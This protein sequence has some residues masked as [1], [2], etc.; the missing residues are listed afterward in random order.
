MRIIRAIGRAVVYL[1][2]AVGAVM[3]IVTTTP[4]VFRWATALAGPWDDPSGDVL[5]VLGGAVTERDLIAADSFLRA[6]YAVLAWRE[7]RFHHI[8]LT[9][10]GDP[11]TPVAKLMRDVLVSHG[12]PDSAIHLETQAHNTRENASY[13]KQMLTQFPGRQVLLTSDYHMYRAYRVF[14][15]QGIDVAPRPFPDARKRAS[16]WT[17]RWPAFLDLVL[18]TV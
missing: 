17:G 8:V 3:V 16:H 4:L 10:G 6:Q 2:A 1:L 14:K 9:G 12:V 13:V 7:G 5:I 11:N 15:K 18:E